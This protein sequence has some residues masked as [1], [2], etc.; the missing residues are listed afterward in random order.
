LVFL[1][2]AEHRAKRRALNLCQDHLRKVMDIARKITQIMDAFMKND[3]ASVARFYEDVQKLG[4]EVDDS[5][6]AIAQELVEIGSVLLNR[7][8]FQRFIDL[9][10]EI[11]DL[12]KGVAFRVLEMME[13]KWDVPSDLKRSTTELASAVFEAISRLRETVLSLNYGSPK[14]AERARDVEIAERNVDNLY[15]KLEINILESNLKI[16]TLL[17]IRDIIQLLEDTADK[18][19]DASDAAWILSFAI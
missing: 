4:D 8:D 16:P 2:E 6:R 13:R 12:C 3:K 14:I 19:E 18:T 9:T 1:I 5:K 17:L 10:S 7:E 15:R 11:V